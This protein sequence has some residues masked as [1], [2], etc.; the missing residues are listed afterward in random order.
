MIDPTGTPSASPTS[1][2]TP[3]STAGMARPSGWG[4][5]RRAAP[6]PEPGS[7]A[8]APGGPLAEKDDEAERDEDQGES[9]RRRLVEAHGELGED[10]RGQRVEAE[11]LEGA[12][13]GQHDQCDEH[14]AAENGQTGLSHRHL[15]ECRHP[16]EA[17]AARHLLLG[18][19]R[20][21]QARR[22][23][24]EDQRIDGQRHD[25]NG[26]PEAPEGGK[27][28]APTEADHEVGYPERDHHQ[29]GPV[30]PTRQPGALDEPGRD[31]P[32]DRAQGGDHHG[33]AHRV[34][35]QLGREPPE[36]ER[37]QRAPSDLDGL[38]DQEDER[39]DHSDGRHQRPQY[40]EPGQAPVVLPP[41][42]PGRARRRPRRD[43]GTLARRSGDDRGHR[44]VTRAAPPGGA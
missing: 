8:M 33:E 41:T 37:I 12:E 28:G 43:R 40:E 9:A 25:E 44:T 27:D 11:D 30:T 18:R 16:A 7:P 21:A 13:L 31:R 10:L 4:R 26:R 29:H 1:S 15:P 2:P 35:D 38:G 36:E 24:Q 3:P 22:D 32:D 20:V 19:I 6:A 14:R 34:P 17:Q 39:Q 23:G 5:I 42:A